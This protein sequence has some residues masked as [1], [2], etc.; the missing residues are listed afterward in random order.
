M[1]VE[2]RMPY[3]DG[4]GL[5]NLPPSPFFRDRDLRLHGPTRGKCWHLVALQQQISET[6]IAELEDVIPSRAEIDFL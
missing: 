4:R 1:R 5:L 2:I 3:P 6:N